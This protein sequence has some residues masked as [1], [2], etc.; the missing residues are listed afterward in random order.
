MGTGETLGIQPLSPGELSANSLPASKTDWV[1][2]GG[3]Q[4][5]EPG[6]HRTAW[7][8]TQVRLGR[9]E[10]TLSVGCF[11]EHT[12]PFILKMSASTLT[13]L[14]QLSPEEPHSEPP[15]PR[16]HCFLESQSSLELSV[17]KN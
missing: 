13:P 11:S 7:K 4:S 16:L 2:H 12:S 14:F 8:V 15:T 6:A 17:L 3:S 5:P 9:E 10:G 1:G